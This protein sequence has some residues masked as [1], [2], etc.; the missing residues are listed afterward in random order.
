MSVVGCDYSASEAFL[1]VAHEGNVINFSKFKLKG[2]LASQRLEYF[3]QLQLEFGDLQ[4]EERCEPILYLEE[5]WVAQGHFVKAAI[6]LARNAAVIEIAAI[7][8]GY[9]VI[10]VHVST[11][12]KGVYGHGKPQDPKGTARE[13]VLENLRYETRN[14]NLAEAACI[15]YYGGHQGQS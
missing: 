7:T 5:P 12:R 9:A 4:S 1:A 8:M 14:H 13:W 2:D 3:R 6:M 10:P 15:S 11:W